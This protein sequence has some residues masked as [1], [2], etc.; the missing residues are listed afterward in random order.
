MGSDADIL[1]I[2][3]HS[4]QARKVHELIGHAGGVMFRALLRLVIVV[5][6]VVG[7]A[8]FLLGWWGS[9]RLHPAERPAA[10]VG[11]AGHVDTEKA[12]AVGAEVGA[13]TAQAANRAEEVLSDAALTAKIK[14]K[15]A[16]DDLVQARTIDVT[17]T[18]HVV[19][20]RGNVRSVAEHDR[21]VQLAKEKAGVSEV[22]DRLGVVR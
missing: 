17:T 6:I 3:T 21:A 7:A 14:S 16:L 4:R 5:V 15:M 19:T 2:F 12:K 8:A 13:K 22:V 18:N 10:T 1:A 11:T 20:L 9:G